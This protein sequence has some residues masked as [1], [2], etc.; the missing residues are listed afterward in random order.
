MPQNNNILKV[1][2]SA[3]N[4]KFHRKTKLQL[5]KG[6]WRVNLKR[7][8][9]SLNS[10]KSNSSSSNTHLLPIIPKRISSVKTSK[11]LVKVN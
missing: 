8:K 1:N 9:V 6:K 11:N 7:T 4:I 5:S 2:L 3:I 10:Q